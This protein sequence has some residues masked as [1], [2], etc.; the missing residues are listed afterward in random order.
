MRDPEIG[1]TVGD[2]YLLEG[3][4]GRGGMGVVF[5]ARHKVSGRKV[6]LKWLR[7]GPGNEAALERFVREAKFLGRIEHANVVGVLDVGTEG[8]SGYLVMEYLR[9]ESLRQLLEREAP[10]AP[11]KAVCLLLPAM[12]GV[13]AAHRAG[14]VHRD[15]KPEN[16]FVTRTAR[17][18]T[19]TRV[20]DFGVSKL[21]PDAHEGDVVPL[22]GTGNLVGT[23]R[24]MAPEQVIAE[25]I[26]ERSDIWALGVILYEMLAGQV[27]FPSSNYGALLVSIA[28]EDVPPLAERRPDVPAE[29]IAIVERALSKDPA[30]RYPTVVEMARALE[31]FADGSEFR[32]PA[33]PSM[34]PPVEAA[35]S[36]PAA[37]PQDG[38]HPDEVATLDAPEEACDAGG[39]EVA[40]NE[41]AARSPT[42]A[43]RVAVAAGVALALGAAGLGLLSPSGDEPEPRATDPRPIAG[44]PAEVEDR[45]TVGASSPTEPVRTV[46]PTEPSVTVE[47]PRPE[48]TPPE[49]PPIVEAPPAPEAP[50]ARAHHREP[51]TPAAATEPTEAPAAEE[52]PSPAG[53]TGALSRDEF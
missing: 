52:P 32:E 25:G 9:G 6:A 11:D 42:P 18:E 30:R 51:R 5:A 44:A 39:S 15:L 17:G 26:D 8:D 2:R 1:D 35:P 48:T 21:R 45:V 28:T 53:V 16:L 24:Y 31:P 46:R 29:L 34:P 49:E 12:E 33:P 14:I 10:L 7:G 36:Q 13:E 50:P 4:L 19:T 41:V 40:A 22:T 37:P 20:L 43:V 3:H 47:A 23:P 27:P 38:P